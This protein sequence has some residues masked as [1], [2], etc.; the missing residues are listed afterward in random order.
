MPRSGANS[1]INQDN[2]PVSLLAEGQ[3][4]IRRVAGFDATTGENARKLVVTSLIS[5]GCSLMRRM[6]SDDS[7]KDMEDL[8]LVTQRCD[9]GAQCLRCKN[10]GLHYRIVM[11]MLSRLK[12]L[13]RPPRKAGQCA[14]M[15]QY[16]TLS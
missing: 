9:H 6:L 13:L 12:G 8:M 7:G 11:N 4:V 10:S 3:C 5:S 16:H 1:L 2:V 14:W 15:V